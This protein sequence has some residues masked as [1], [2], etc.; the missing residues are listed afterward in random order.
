MIAVSGE[1]RS[2]ETARSR[3]VLIT[4]LTA[5][6]LRLH[7]GCLQL[8]AL[9]RRP[10]KRFERRDDPRSD[11]R[12]HRGVGSGPEHERRPAIGAEVQRDAGRVVVRRGFQV[13]RTPRRPSA[14][15]ISSPAAGSASASVAPPSSTRAVSAARSASPRR[16]SASAARVRATSATRDAIAAVTRYTPSAT[17][18]LE[19]AIEM[20][21]IGGM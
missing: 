9:E 6:R 5:Q 18:W 2:C 8:V 21:P 14:V 16:R 20:P 1:R 12:Q 3:A 19:S 13:S 10:Q 15:P 17:Q 7:D 11:A 4:S